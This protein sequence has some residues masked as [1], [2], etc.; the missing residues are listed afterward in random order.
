MRSRT[1]RTCQ[2]HL[3][4]K[5][6]LRLGWPPHCHSA[7]ATVELTHFSRQLLE[8]HLLWAGPYG[9]SQFSFSTDIFAEKALRERL[10][11]GCPPKNNRNLGKTQLCVLVKSAVCVVSHGA[12]SASSGLNTTWN[13][14]EKKIDIVPVLFRPLAETV[15]FRFSFQCNKKIC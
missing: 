15:L 12:S 6:F 9:K 1:T 14:M 8:R 3:L 2:K 7:T 13:Y 5:H 11:C 10:E 4:E